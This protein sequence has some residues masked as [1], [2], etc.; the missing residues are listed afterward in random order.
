MIDGLKKIYRK[1]RQYFIQLNRVILNAIFPRFCKRFMASCFL[2]KDLALAIEVV[3]P[4]L[5]RQPDLD[6]MPFDLPVQD[7]LEFQHLAGLFASNSFNHAVSGLTFRM[8][9]YTFGLLRQMKAQKVIEVGRHKGGST[10]LMAAAIG[11]SGEI[12]SIDIG[13]KEA[14]V[15]QDAKRPFDEQLADVCKRLNLNV[16][17]VVGDSRL[18]EIETGEVD[19]VFIDGEHTYDAV[20]ND[21]ERFGKRV[22]MG[23]AIL[24]DDCSGDST[25]ALSPAYMTPLIDEIVLS[26]TFEL[27]KTVDRLGHFKRVKAL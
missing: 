10:L 1:L 9:A 21:F 15:N 6:G 3:G 7:Q 16:H 26:G 2:E 17:M 14:R 5:N 25:F 19:L 22:R 20:K 27:I 12:W 11:H 18:I 8:A 4:K 13:E 23:G 24:F